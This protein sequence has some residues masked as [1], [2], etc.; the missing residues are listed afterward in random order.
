M[1]IYDNEQLDAIAQQTLLNSAQGYDYVQPAM[2]FLY[3]TGCRPNEIF[4]IP[5]F[6]YYSE[7]YYQLQPS[8]F[9]LPRLI[10]SG[11]F[12]EQS[13][14]LIS[15]GKAPFYPFSERRLLD[16]FKRY[17][18]S[19]PLLCGGKDIQLYIFRHLYI[20]LLSEAGL[21]DQEIATE[22]G[23]TSTAVVRGY[24]DSVIYSI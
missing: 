18:A 6:T 22:M 14:D 7:A 12:T 9:N 13:K 15:M 3:F 10:I 2:Y 23:Y 20:R 21:T 4:G 19:P 1:T 16:Y 5:R 17:R 24:I 11:L 8:K